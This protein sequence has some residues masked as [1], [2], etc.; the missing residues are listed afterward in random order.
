MTAPIQPVGGSAGYISLPVTTDPDQLATNALGYLAAQLPGFVARDGHLEVYLIRAFARMVAETAQVAAQVPLA[1]F[2]Y[3]GTQLL[4]LPPMTGAFASM[5]STWTLNDM[6]GHLIPAGTVVAYRVSGSQ[7]ILFTTTADVTVAAG[8][9]VTAAGAVTLQAVITGSAA[10]GLAPASV[11]MVNNLSYVQSVATTTISAGGA[12]AETQ[13]AYL[14]RLSNQLQLL[15]PRP[16]LPS[17]F[18]TVALNQAG[19]GRAT[20]LDGYNPANGTAGNPRMITVAVTDIN[21][22]ALTTAQK[23]TISSALQAQREVNFVV[24]VVDPTYS[25]VNVTAT[26]VGQRGLNTNTITAAATAKLTSYLSPATWGGG[27]SAWVNTFIVRYLTIGGLLDD[28]PGVQYVSALTISVGAGALA[29]A[30]ATLPGVLPLPTVGTLSI[31][32]Q[33][34]T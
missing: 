28:I 23:A 8:S 13:T 10:N 31:I 25:T 9:N 33:P 11:A 34:G 3:F 19:V 7:T 21:G 2:Q 29:A 20:Y 1:V 12:N 4:G 26:L 16:I 30:D 15:A 17:D 6:L 22:N 18:A 27:P 14:N 5:T 32:T 24:N